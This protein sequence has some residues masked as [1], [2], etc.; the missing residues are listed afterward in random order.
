MSYESKLR[1]DHYEDT[2]LCRYCGWSG[3]VRRRRTSVGKAVVTYCPGCCK[4]VKVLAG[5]N[6]NGEK[7][8]AASK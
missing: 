3:I 8:G 4:S 7:V 2:Y 6:P 5:S 1:N